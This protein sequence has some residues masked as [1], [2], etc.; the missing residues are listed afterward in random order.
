LGNII[1][2][3]APKSK[4]SW[5]FLEAQNTISGSAIYFFDKFH[6]PFP[7][8]GFSNTSKDISFLV[9]IARMFSNASISPS[10]MLYSRF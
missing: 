6:L 2:I 4:G 1:L 3:S 7:I 8:H 10:T 5:K 9:H